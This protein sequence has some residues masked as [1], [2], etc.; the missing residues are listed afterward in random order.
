MLAIRARAPVDACA[1]DD[2]PPDDTPDPPR[3]AA[4][5]EIVAG[6]RRRS[7][8]PRP[9]GNAK[10]MSGTLNAAACSRTFGIVPPPPR[11][12]QC[13]VASSAVGHG[14]R[15]GRAPPR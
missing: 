4:P 14:A 12:R 9:G 13:P 11:R 3:G 15:G 5:P 6:P 7:V 2:S 10:D 1:P 8:V